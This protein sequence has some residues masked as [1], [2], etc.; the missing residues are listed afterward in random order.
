MSAQVY[1]VPGQTKGRRNAFLVWKSIDLSYLLHLVVILTIIKVFIILFL[2]VRIGNIL[3]QNKSVTSAFNWVSRCILFLAK[4]KGRGRPFLKG[5]RSGSHIVKLPPRALGCH[6]RWKSLSF[7]K[8]W[9]NPTLP[10]FFI[11]SPYK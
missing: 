1:S 10:F 6:K 9:N 3:S 11:W 7:C 5:A 2:L 4:L 8:I